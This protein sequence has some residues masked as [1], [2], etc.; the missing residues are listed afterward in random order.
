MK[1]PF[2]IIAVLVMTFFPPILALYFTGKEISQYL[3]FPPYTRFVRHSPFSYPVFTLFLFVEVFLYY[4]FSKLFLSCLKQRKFNFSLRASFPFWGYVGAA[5]GLILWILAWSR[6]KWFSQF[7]AYTFTPLW[8]S[9]IVVINAMIYSVSGTC[10]IKR[11]P[12]KFFLLF[13]A[14]SL[15]WW[16]FEYL[17]RFVQNWYYV[18]VNQEAFS[19]FIHASFSFSTVL[20]AIVC[21]KELLTKTLF[22]NSDA[23]A[24]DE[25][26]TRHSITL[27]FLFILIS[28]T[29]LF[30]MS[31][32]PEYLFFMMWVAP[33]FLITGVQLISKEKHIFSSVL[34]KGKWS[35]VMS[36][37][38]SGIICGFFWE[39]W[40]FYS[41][42]KWKYSIP[43]VS[44]FYVFEM[45]LLGFAGYLPFGLVCGAFVQMLSLDDL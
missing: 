31:L 34:T 29:G 13:P 36:F 8:I 32:F 21:T 44:K 17:N 10:P 4:Y 41:F 5:T 12:F 19:Y 7:Q 11:S 28:C 38:S 22:L 20:P 37:C 40:N 23:Q 45:P 9:Y 18:N 42:A 1:I 30:L 35:E 2:K 3:K 27:G 14:S 15:F 43:F 24:T 6:F 33:L 26:N 25:I 16:M 39:M